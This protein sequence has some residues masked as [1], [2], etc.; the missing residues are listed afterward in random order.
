MLVLWEIEVL[1]V[2]SVIIQY[3]KAPAGFYIYLDLLDL[4]TK[5]VVFTAA[6]F[7]LS[8]LH[9]VMYREKIFVQKIFGV[10]MVLLIPIL[11]RYG[12]FL[13]LIPYTLIVFSISYWIKRRR[14]ARIIVI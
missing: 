8:V 2:I 4:D 1:R 10:S 9:L 5:I 12:G 3:K 14:Q 7:F 11:A 13:S 6:A